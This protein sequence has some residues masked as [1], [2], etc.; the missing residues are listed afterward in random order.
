MDKNHNGAAD[1]AGVAGLI[2]IRSDKYYYVGKLDSSAKAAMG[3]SGFGPG[4]I[5]LKDAYELVVQHRPQQSGA[6]EM[7]LL[8]LPIGPFEGPTKIIARVDA[9]LDLSTCENMINLNRVMTGGSGLLI[10][11]MGPLRPRGT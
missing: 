5:A 10:P 2:G 7:T 6:I 3:A 11:G 4:Y 1:V 8:P 9:F